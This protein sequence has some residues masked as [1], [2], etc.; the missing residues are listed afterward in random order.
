MNILAFLRYSL[1]SIPH[2]GSIVTDFFA[3]LEEAATGF[4][5]LLSAIVAGVEGLF[6]A[7]PVAP[8]T[9]GT[10]T[11]LGIMTVAGLVIGIVYKLIGWVKSAIK[12]RG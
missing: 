5:D 4:M 6:Y 11:L 12:M 3:T 8:A 7:P 10:F 1:R 2:F 9:E